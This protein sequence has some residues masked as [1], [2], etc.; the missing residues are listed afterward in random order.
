[1]RTSPLSPHG[2]SVVRVP[3]NNTF[4]QLN[5][6]SSIHQAWSAFPNS[7]AGRLSSLDNPPTLLA[8]ADEVIE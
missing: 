7:H 1:V 3:R 8:R 5:I 2:A 4:L 6:A